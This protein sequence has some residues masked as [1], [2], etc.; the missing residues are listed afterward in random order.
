MVR[1]GWAKADQHAAFGYTGSFTAACWWK[2]AGVAANQGLIGKGGS[3]AGWGLRL[4][5]GGLL[6]GFVGNGASLRTATGA[7]V[8]A[9]G[10]W[11]FVG[12]RWNATTNAVDVWL[13]DRLEAQTGGGAFSVS[14]AG[15]NFRVAAAFN[16]AGSAEFAG[17]AFSA[18]WAVG[19]YLSDTQMRAALERGLWAALGSPASLWNGT[20]P[21]LDPR[22]GATNTLELRADHGTTAPTPRIMADWRSRYA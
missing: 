18:A 21:V 10:T 11:Y 5:N 13:Y 9:V 3:N 12:I 7:T 14:A 22:A 1:Q 19:A 2:P 15:N 4:L 8:L 17:G 6:Y 16:G 20:F